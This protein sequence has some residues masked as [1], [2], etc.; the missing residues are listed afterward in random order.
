MLDRNV[1]HRNLAPAAQTAVTTPISLPSQS[2]AGRTRIW[3]PILVTVAV[4]GSLTGTAQDR[5]KTMPGYARFERLAREIPGSVKLG[6]LNVTWEDEG[7]AFEY[8]RKGK[9]F[10]YDVDAQI[11]AELPP[12]TNQTA[13]AEEAPKE[14]APE[15]GRQYTSATSPDLSLIHI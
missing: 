12:S 8:S 3:M 14:E 9:R 10:R 11:A 15:R 4:L 5:L 6:T 1:A 13:K 2:R 7:R